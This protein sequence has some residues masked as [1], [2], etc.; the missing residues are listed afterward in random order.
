MAIVALFTHKEKSTLS[1]QI[2]YFKI[3][4]LFIYFLLLIGSNHD[5]K[6][7]VSNF[8]LDLLKYAVIKVSTFQQIHKKAWTAEA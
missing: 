5:F 4:K 1:R 2:F 6:R 3:L 8:V 7:K